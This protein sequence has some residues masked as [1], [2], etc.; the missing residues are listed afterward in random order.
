MLGLGMVARIK[1]WITPE[2]KAG[3]Y[4]LVMKILFPVMIFNLM[5]STK[6]QASHLSI[7]AYVVIAYLIILVIGKLLAPVT[8]KKFAH[9]SNYLLV[10]DEGGNVALPLYLSIVGTSS[11][12]VIFDLAGSFM[13]FVIV[14][15]LI[16]RQTSGGTSVKDLLK[17]IFTNSF[18]LAV[19]AGLILNFTGFYAWLETSEFFGLYEGTISMITAPISSLILFSLG[20]DLNM[21]KEIL[22]P[23]MKL[24]AL[25]AVTHAVIIA[26]FFL[27]FPGLMS[28][29]I[30]RIAVFIYFMCPTGF[31]LPSIISPVFKG[32]E[33]EEFASSFV[34]V[35]MII[36][37]IV[38]AAV[39]ILA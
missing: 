25:R 14:P 21:D 1:N 3:A 36:T 10:T 27:F 16:A 33:D 17:S 11:N 24:A 12:T 9:L 30:F 39:V 23:I 31:A 7:I 18:I 38:Y 8:G 32:R 37:L 6:F 13:A 19:L 20:Y 35:Y 2:Q 28:D 5:I 34:S 22:G 29:K 15:V 26:G 4:S